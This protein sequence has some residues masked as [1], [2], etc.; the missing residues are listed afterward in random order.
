MRWTVA[1]Y[2]RLLLFSALYAPQGLIRGFLTVALAA[3]L[4]QAGLADSAVSVLIGT[5]LLPWSFKL[6][7]GPIVDAVR[8]P[9]VEGNRRPW[10]LLA[11]VG[12]CGCLALIADIAD[13]VTALSS[14]TIL[15]FVC[16]VCISIQD[17]ATDA[18]A[19]DTL[20]LDELGFTN[21]AMLLSQMAAQAAGAAGT[22][23]LMKHVGFS[24]AI[25][26][27]VGCLLLLLFVPVRTRESEIGGCEA[28]GGTRQGV[29]RRSLLAPLGGLRDALRNRT[30]AVFC[31][32]GAVVSFGEGLV[33][34]IVKPF[35]LRRLG[36]DAADYSV[37]VGGSVLPQ[38][39]AAVV[40]G[41]VLARAG[42]G[43]IPIRVG[44]V[45]YGVC[46]ALVA[47]FGGSSTGV[48]WAYVV[49]APAVL[50]YASIA[51][52]AFAMTVARSQHAATVFAAVMTMCSIG[53]VSGTYVGG[54]LRDGAGMEYETLLLTSSLGFV[55]ACGL[56]RYCENNLGVIS[57]AR[58]A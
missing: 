2:R 40:A 28:P 17:I 35:Y 49:L 27:M 20:P 46:S 29:T 7:W 57:E 37:L 32:F 33:G 39:L 4:L 48:A 6:I 12:M 52:L 13:P 50:T 23:L 56:L 14:L 18:L 30:M 24:A 9:F 3:H 19:I 11:Q 15:F 25:W 34:F 47:V 10:V 26:A 54:M 1:R 21:G 16:N 51:F 58:A 45:L 22:A 5:A 42:D 31:V 36:W 38:I 43:R 41:L 53:G 55:L 8:I 44:Y